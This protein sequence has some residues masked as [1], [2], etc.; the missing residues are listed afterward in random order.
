MGAMGYLIH[1][2]L[3]ERLRAS[4]FNVYDLRNIK[5]HSRPRIAVAETAFSQT[6]RTCLMRARLEAERRVC[7]S[8]AMN[9]TGIDGSLPVRLTQR[10]QLALTLD[11]RTHHAVVGKWDHTR[12]A[13]A[14]AALQ[15]LYI[16]FNIRAEKPT[17][18]LASVCALDSGD[19]DSN[20][21]FAKPVDGPAVASTIEVWE[22]TRRNQL[23]AEFKQEFRAFS[24]WCLDI[25]W[26]AYG[27][28]H[29]AT[30]IP[31]DPASIDPFVHLMHVNLLP[32]IAKMPSL[33]SR[34][35]LLLTH[36]R[37]SVASLPAASFAE[38]INSAA[39]IISTKKNVLLAHNEISHLVTLRVNAALLRY[40]R[41]KFASDDAVVAVDGAE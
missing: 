2:R 21:M 26:H 4:S 7:G 27:A 25:D 34:F 36:S 41:V 13:A 17:A 3:L 6:G 1:S 9:V 32:L 33:L 37:G 20:D 10:E 16:D 8:T 22:N 29:G 24:K 18:D 12:R 11:P 5:M 35:K 30:W 28:Q 38:R 19:D 40:L 15:T 23:E 31:A 39:G 14:V